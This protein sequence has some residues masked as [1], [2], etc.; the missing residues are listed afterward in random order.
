[1]VSGLL[2][3]AEGHAG[4]YFD[5]AWGEIARLGGG[6]RAKR[7]LN[8]ARIGFLGHTYPGML[9]MYS[10]FTMHHAQLGAHVEVLE[11]DDLP[12]T[13]PPGHRCRIA[14]NGQIRPVFEI[15]Q[16]GRDK[17]SMPVTEESLRWSAGW[18]SASTGW[19]PTSTWMA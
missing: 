5:R 18:R 13:R 6:G 9:D 8:S 11:M 3:P 15:A 17:I 7:T 2:G 10:D 14:A 4:L 1:M 12:G 19:Q 16:P